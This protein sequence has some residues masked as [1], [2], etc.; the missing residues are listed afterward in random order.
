MART[1]CTLVGGVTVTLVPMAVLRV[2]LFSAELNI[3]SSTSVRLLLAAVAAV[4]ASNCTLMLTLTTA[5]TEGPPPD[6]CV[7]GLSSVTP[8]VA[9]W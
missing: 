2:P 8:K 9:S 7:P 4:W 1:L 3:A 5:E 6:P